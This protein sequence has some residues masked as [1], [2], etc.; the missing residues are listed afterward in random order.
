MDED[1]DVND[2]TAMEVL[3][4]MVE[5]S[6]QQSKVLVRLEQTKSTLWLKEDKE[7][8]EVAKVQTW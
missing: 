7:M 5:L 1:K 6:L 2:E 3:G 8:M 4:L